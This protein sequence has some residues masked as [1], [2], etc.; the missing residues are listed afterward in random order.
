[1]QT[2]SEAKRVERVGGGKICGLIIENN[3]EQLDFID[4]I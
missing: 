2:K 3:D 4:H 1:M